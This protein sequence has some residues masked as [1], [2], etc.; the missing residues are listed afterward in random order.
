MRLERR[1]R[2]HALPPAGVWC[3]CAPC[4]Q[5]MCGRHSQGGMTPHTRK[6][7]RNQEKVLFITYRYEYSVKVKG[8]CWQLE[9]VGRI[10]EYSTHV[11]LISRPQKS[12]KLCNIRHMHIDSPTPN[13]A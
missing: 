13:T 4:R 5:S 11:S 2:R 8:N 6:D 7:V 1:H 12:I 9:A 3:L 10:L